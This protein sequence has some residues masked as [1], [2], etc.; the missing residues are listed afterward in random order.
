MSSTRAQQEAAELLTY[1]ANEGI[2]L[3]R[4]SRE[5]KKPVDP[6]WQRQTVPF[7]DVVTWVARGGNV[8]WQ[9][10]E[11]SD[12]R[13]AV[14]PD[15]PEAEKLAPTFLPD[16]LK[17]GKGG[18]PS[19]YF[20]R[21]P[22]LGFDTFKDLDGNTIMDLKASNNG[23]GHQV[24][25]EPSVHPDKGPY[26]WV[27]GYNPAAIREIPA[28]DL[29]VLVGELATA[30]LIARHLPARG[31]HDL[32]MALAGYML[33]NGMGVAEVL[34]V[35]TAAW[36][37]NVPPR[38]AFRDLQ[39][40][41]RDTSIRL[42]RNEP[43]TGGRTLEEL[44]PG[45]PARIAKF[46]G[47]ERPVHR[48]LRRHYARSDLGNAERF[49]DMH[50]DSVRWCPARKS[51][52]V[53]D[54][55]RW[56]WDECGQIVKLAQETARSIHRDA[57][58]EEDLAKQREIARF[59][60]S[61]QNEGR[62]NGMLSQAK[63]HLAVR[64]EDLDRDQWLLNCQNGT[65]DLRTG[66]LRGHDPADYITTMVPVKYTPDA[67]RERFEKYLEEVLVDRA[68]ISFVKRYCGY[69]LTGI[70]RER[71]LAIVWGSGK[72]GKTTLV[73]LLRDVMG[74]YAQNTD[75]ETILIKR[76]AGVGNDVAALRGARFVSC[77]EV[78][79]GRRLDESKVKQLTGNDTVTARYLFGEPF[80][81][82]PQFKLWISTN[83][84]PEVQGTDDAIWD[85][86]RLIPFTQ[87]FDGDRQDS[88]LPDKLRA[89]SE[90]VLAWM[91]EGCLEWQEHGLGEPE[92]VA[93]AT[94]DYRTE[95]DTLAAFMDEHCVTG[96]GFKVLAERLYEHYSIWCD[97]SGERR[98]P[99]KAFVARL[100]ERGFTR[101]RESAG[102]NKGRYVW[103]GIGLRDD[104]RPPE[105]GDLGSPSEPSS[106]EGSLRA[107]R[108]DKQKTANTRSDGEP[109]EAKNQNVQGEKPREEEDV[110]SGFT[111][112][113]GF[114]PNQDLTVE[115]VLQVLADPSTGA[116]KNALRYSVGETALEYLVRS[117][118]FAKGISTE[119]WQ[120]HT[121]VVEE[122]FKEWRKRRA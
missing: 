30:V 114:T 31:R 41:V 99:K 81:F 120:Q 9:V 85:R 45:M 121:G 87:R 64:L 37:L 32:A 10:G 88:K 104:G 117:V 49:V 66:K 113:T 57:A 103:V 100:T 38:E 46:L 86:I 72:N 51:W 105:D 13:C 89:E 73:E 93:A 43:V 77:A 25:V 70:T 94:K 109:S 39:G 53:Y 48:E 3:V 7:D 17:A 55:R 80:N 56:S 69:T 108:Q 35:L 68:V 34:K 18:V 11:I 79:R 95:M 52:L 62:I 118:L 110:D 14:D 22:G 28:A 111:G 26:K 84:K 122:A 60:I 71:I 67:G 15:C 107:F 1:Y 119:G 27:G 112:F 58:T 20:Y 83:N 101:R 91:V 61:S 96:P 63:P 97:K 6:G 90:G 78:G 115:G 4:V 8:G 47:W 16:T 33:R 92:R 21:S 76:Y 74:D 75:V 44:I 5:T 82:R 24:V 116:H 29:R 106:E 36:E 65:L 23:A 12:W 40:I 98:D 102:V 42:E 19:L 50:G 2:K 59:A 54:G